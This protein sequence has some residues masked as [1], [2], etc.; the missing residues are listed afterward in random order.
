MSA[1]AE[2]SEATR[3]IVRGG[4]GRSLPMIR[5][6]RS[7]RLG[8][9]RP[10]GARRPAA[11]PI[12]LGVSRP[13]RSSAIFSTRTSTSVR[14]SRPCVTGCAAPSDPRSDA[15]RWRTTNATR[16]SGRRS[17]ARG[18]YL[19]RDSL[20]QFTAP[21]GR[22]G[23]RSAELVPPSPRSQANPASITRPPSEL[24]A[25]SVPHN[26]SPPGSFD[27]QVAHGPFPRYRHRGPSART[28]TG[29]GPAGRWF[30]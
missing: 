13:A 3:C 7:L 27:S 2:K 26:G 28:R 11:M 6:E 9:A 22:C 17:R 25:S 30:G 18:R 21:A 29:C 4:V 19:R 24:L 8:P 5:L 14:S 10:V 15:T 16:C 23:C 1:R 12:P 20:A